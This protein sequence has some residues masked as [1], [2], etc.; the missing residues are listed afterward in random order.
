MASSQTSAVILARVSTSKQETDRQLTEL[1]MYAIAKGYRVI[2]EISETVSGRADEKDRPD[3]ARVRELARAGAIKK[4]LVHEISRISRRNSIVH[5]FVE[6][7]ES[8]GVSVYWASQAIETLD[9]RGKRNPAASIML[10]V[11]AEMGRHEVEVLR[12]RIRSGL[13]E[14]RRRGKRLG[15][16]VGGVPAEEILSKHRDIVRHLKAGRSIRETAKL[17]AAPGQRD[18]TSTV[19]RV[20][21]LLG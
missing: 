12:E 17:C 15:R 7:M 4:V 20:K 19:K 11:L 16:P 1:R 6:E 18:I 2:E 8:L 13:D 5:A 3:L 10:S 21:R 14:A 9:D